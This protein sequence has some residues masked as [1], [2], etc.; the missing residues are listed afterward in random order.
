MNDKPNNS[1]NSDLPDELSDAEKIVTASE[2]PDDVAEAEEVVTASD[3][4]GDVAEAELAEMADK[5]SAP[6]AVARFDNNAGKHRVA[7][8]SRSKTVSH[9]DFKKRSRRSVLTSGV[10]AAAAFIGWRTLQGRPV[11]ERIP[12]VLRAGHG[13]NER[14]WRGLFRE[15]ALAPTFDFEESS[16]LRVNGRHGLD[17][18]PNIAFQV[19]GRDGAVLGIH[20][21]DDLREMPQTEMTIEH[22]CVEGWSHI[23][24]WGGVTFREFAERFYPEEMDAQFVGLSTPDGEYNVGLDMASM[25]HPQ[26]ML[27]ID[28]Q[29]VPLTSDHG[30]PVRLTTPLKYGI[31]QIKR[32]GNIRFSDTQPENDYCCLLYTS[33]SPRDATLSRMPS[34]A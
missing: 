12:D 19:F 11:D 4:S 20:S 14:I 6:A 32:I 3:P 16:F 13:V 10:A 30:A 23:V 31:K 29:R 27:S 9:A 1:T 2:L 21:V 5:A 15:N 25:L 8:D 28:L 18:D 34:S 33:P 7:A 17:G 22:Y 26:T 24:T